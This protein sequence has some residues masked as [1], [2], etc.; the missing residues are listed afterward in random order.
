MSD[1]TAPA[2]ACNNK[3]SDGIEGMSGLHKAPSSSQLIGK[4]TKSSFV[5][6]FFLVYFSD[7]KKSLQKIPKST[8]Q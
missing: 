7:H 5:T 3:L 4:S 1:T 6:N 8:R 2:T